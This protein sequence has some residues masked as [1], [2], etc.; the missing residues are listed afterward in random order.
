LLDIA[1]VVDYSGTIRDSNV[2]S[3][4]NWMH[5]IN[6][7]VRVVSSLNIGVSETHVGAVSFG[8]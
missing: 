6:F 2:G 1:F 3:D 4:D 8:K 7:M 5:V